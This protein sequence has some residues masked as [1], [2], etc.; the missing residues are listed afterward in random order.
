[1]EDD[2][3]RPIKVFVG[4]MVL[5]VW[6]VMLGTD[7]WVATK[8]EPVW[9]QRLASV[10]AV[11]L[12]VTFGATRFL[13]TEINKAAEGRGPLVELF[14]EKLG[15]VMHSEDKGWLN[16]MDADGREYERPLR[17]ESEIRDLLVDLEDFIG[18]KVQPAEILIGIKLA[19]QGGY[20]DAAVCL[21]NGKGFGSC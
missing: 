20:G 2:V 3:L 11:L 7:F 15:P 12:I 6:L 4:L 21:L 14:K 16:Y 1:M 8:Y 13:I 9:F 17:Q 5:A 19:L 10:W 18:L